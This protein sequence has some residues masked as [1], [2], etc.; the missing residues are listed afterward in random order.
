[1]YLEVASV[2]CCEMFLLVISLEVEDEN[3]VSKL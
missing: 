3:D 1:M 2:F